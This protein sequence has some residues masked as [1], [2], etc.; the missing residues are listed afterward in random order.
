[1]RN[2]RPIVTFTFD[3]FPQ[4]AAIEGAAILEDAGARGTFY[5]A[6]GTMGRPQDLEPG[7]AVEPDLIA[8]SQ[9]VDQL[10]RAGHEIGCHTFSHVSTQGMPRQ[11][12]AR[13]C[14]E[15][16]ALQ[17][18]DGRD[19]RLTSFAYPFGRVSLRGKR[20]AARH[21][22]SSRGLLTDVNAGHADLAYLRAVSLQNSSMDVAGVDR[23][24]SAATQ[25]GGW[26]I[27]CCHDVR[28][29]PSR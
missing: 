27:F 19:R 8:T 2:P 20:E 3:D 23:W 26:L 25:V 9:Q 21:H 28:P 11:Q 7:S 18:A 5:L 10:A 29:T 14:Q 24:L 6:G 1:M 16:H 13:Q 4:S 15:N 12:I 17:L 22:V